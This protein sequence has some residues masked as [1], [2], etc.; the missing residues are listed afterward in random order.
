MMARCALYV[1]EDARTILSVT[2]SAISPQPQNITS[3]NISLPPSNVIINEQY[4][5]STKYY[6]NEHYIMNISTTTNHYI[7]EQFSI[8][9][10]Y[11]NEYYILNIFFRATKN[12]AK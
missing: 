5:T 7:S 4:S 3:M 10:H 11:M 1:R 8:T 6:A 9:K 12:Y 2:T